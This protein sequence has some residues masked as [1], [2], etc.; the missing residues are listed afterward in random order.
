[1]L[2][3]NNLQTHPR[4]YVGLI[5][6]LVGIISAATLMLEPARPA[7][8]QIAA[9]SWSYTGNLNPARD[10]HTATLLPNGKV[11]AKSHDNFSFTT[12][13]YPGA[14]ISTGWGINSAGDIIGTYTYGNQHPQVGIVINKPAYGY[15]LNANGARWNGTDSICNEYDQEGSQCLTSLDLPG[16][17]HSLPYAISDNGTIVGVYTEKTLD[18]TSGRIHCFILHNNE[19]TLCDLPGAR[20]NS[21]WGI[22][23]QGDVVGRYVLPDG[24]AHGFLLHQGEYTSIDYPGAA[25]T[26][27]RGITPSGEIVGL[28]VDV[29]GATHG[30]LLMDGEFT[31]IEYPGAVFTNILGVNARGDIVGRYDSADGKQHG[32]LFS[33]G[34]FT[35]IDF[36]GAVRTVARGINLRG[37]IVGEYV[38]PAGKIHAFLMSTLPHS[39]SQL[40]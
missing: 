4:R 17:F 11:P 34:H 13:D 21:A 2:T 8:A 18:N 23:A 32:Y 26:W 37:E 3:S 7:S 16:A 38:T 10:Q 22:N 40:N 35:R 39:R 30:F 1:M 5:L 6:A 19:L 33:R 12:I 24:S 20:S 29:T 27:A 31:S 15:L 28:Y 14:N 25:S 36:P 9:P